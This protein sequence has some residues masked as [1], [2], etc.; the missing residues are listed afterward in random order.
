MD[1]TQV[2]NSASTEDRKAAAEQL[3]A[4]VELANFEASGVLK[5]IDEL[6][7]GSPVAKEGGALLFSALTDKFKAAAVPYLYPKLTK[8]IELTGGKSQE[9]RAA[10]EEA[11]KKFAKKMPAFSVNL[12]FDDILALA[13]NSTKWQVKC[14]AMIVMGLFVNNAPDQISE[15]MVTIVPVISALMWDSKTKVKKQATKSLKKLCTAI[16]NKDVEPFIPALISAI[17]K[18]EEVEECVHELAATTFVQTVTASALAVT[19]PLLDRGFRERKIATKRKCA[20]ITEN[21]AKLVEDP[22]DVAPFMPVLEPHL[23]RAKE[24]VADPECRTRCAAAHQELVNIGNR[25]EKTQVEPMDETE[26]KK[27]ITAIFAKAGTANAPAAVVDYVVKV[28]SFIAK[29]V[30]ADDEDWKDDMVPAIKAATGKTGDEAALMASQL[31]AELAANASDA[32][33]MEDDDNDAEKLCDCRFSLAYGSRILL[34]NARLNL[35][36]GMRYGIVAAKSAGKTTLLRSISNGQLEGFPVDTCKTVFVEH[37]IQASQARMNVIEFTLDTIGDEGVSEDD[38]KNILT[39][40][41]FTQIMQTGPITS[42]SGG[43]KMKLALARAMLRKADILLLDEPTNHLDVVNVQWVVDYLTGDVCT[44]VT[45]LI[46]SHD[47]KFL[48]NVATHIIHFDALKL[49]NYVGNLSKFVERF[50]HAK[51]YYDL[52]QSSLEFKFPLPGPLD[53]VKS[54]GRAI[55]S[56]TDVEF[57]YPGQEKA[58]LKNINIRVSM[59]SR[60]ACVGANGAGKST[61]IKLLTGELKPGT[62]TVYKHPNCNFAYVA[63]HAFHHIEQHLSKTPTEYIMWRYSGGEDKEALQ[64]STVKITDEEKEIMKKPML[65]SWE[66]EE[67]KKQK[68][69]RVVERIISRRKQGKIYEYEVKFE[70]KAQDANMWFPRDELIDLG[71]KKLLEEVDRRKAAQESAFARV[72]SKANVEKHFENVGL[73][74]EL[75]SHNRISALSGGQKVKVVLAAFTWSQPHL[76]IL[77]EPTNYLDREALGALAKAINNFEGGICLIT[78]NQEFADATTRETW[79]VANN[80]CDIKGDADWTAY[81]AEA[82]EL[83]LSYK[84]DR[85]DALGNK[86]EMKRTPASVKLKEKKKMMKELKKRLKTD[87]E[88]RLNEFE[89]ACCN[90]WGIFEDL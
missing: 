76:I 55:L 72:L 37:D 39:D 78:H 41:G 6:F 28:A 40:I 9:V 34:N 49:N 79:V 25:A 18:P 65:V 17:S 24:E 68:E 32:E 31:K 77:D 53:G 59:A 46:V 42:L 64:K 80:T 27:K 38:V 84:E 90:E 45:S 66:D 10:T 5:T 85:V 36:R 62:G 29:N 11:A 12:V 69:K 19:V 57:A 67:G 2:L 23:A 74:R 54:K 61:M 87:P 35:K 7:G 83:D 75:A 52:S 88:C 15:R 43:W 1:V 56:M 26:A 60:I 30:D 14:L 82:I 8:V 13:E 51:A 63:Q 50:P 47:T 73:D 3:A 20:V 44:N 48:D 21:M 81:A 16:D 89:E 4:G 58:Q 71:F 33:V 86:I 70:K 22:A